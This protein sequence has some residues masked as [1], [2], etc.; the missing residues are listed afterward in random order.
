[1]VSQ[2]GKGTKIQVEYISRQPGGS[3]FMLVMVG[4]QRPAIRFAVCLNMPAADVE[5]EY[6]ALILAP[7]WMF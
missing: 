3:R 5:R 1:M 2:F 4:G 7:R 6:C